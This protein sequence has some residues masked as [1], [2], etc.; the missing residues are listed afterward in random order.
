MGITTSSARLLCNLKRTTDIDYSNTLMLGRQN[1]HMEKHRVQKMFSDYRDVLQNDDI[2]DLYCEKLFLSLGAKTINS[3]DASAYEDATIIHDLNQSIPSEWEESYTC[4]VDG[5]TTEHIFN[6]P[7]AIENV[8]RMLKIGG[9]YVGMVPSNN[10]NGHGFYQFS[11][12]LY[13]QLFC[14][15]NHF[16]LKKMYMSRNSSKH[17]WELVN[18]DPIRRIEINGKTPENLYIVAKKTAL[19]PEKITLQQRDFVEDWKEGPKVSKLRKFLGE[20]LTRIAKIISPV[21]KQQTIVFY[22][23]LMQEKKILSKTRV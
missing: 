14:E 2:L 20:D 6:F 19:T 23:H 9:Y 4:I 11:P 1:L 3:M 18:L 22:Y 17:L 10:Y 12:M 15:N 8:M 7:Q 5:G 13:I 21:E 16:E